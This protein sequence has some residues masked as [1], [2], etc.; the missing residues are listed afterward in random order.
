MTNPNEN[1]QQIKAA[2]K[3]KVSSRA[4]KAS[5]VSSNRV[6][7]I[8]TLVS[9]KAEDSRSPVSSSKTPARAPAGSEAELIRANI[10]AFVRSNPAVS[11]GDLVGVLHL[12]GSGLM[13]NVSFSRVVS[14]LAASRC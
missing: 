10:R 13:P 14:P 5:R 9:S 8:R 3:T 4:G 2:I 6:A 1:T 12:E 11:R 7:D